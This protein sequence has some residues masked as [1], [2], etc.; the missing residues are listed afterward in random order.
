MLIPALEM[1]N[2]FLEEARYDLLNRRSYLCM[3]NEVVNYFLK[4]LCLHMLL[5]CY[6]FLVKTNIRE[7][8]SLLLT[9]LSI[10][11]CAEE[12]GCLLPRHFNIDLDATPTLLSSSL[13]TSKRKE[14]RNTRFA[15]YYKIW[16]KN[17]TVIRW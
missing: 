9:S 12:I 5:L 14:K 15:S 10:L 7:Y 8:V 4:Q 1:I 17:K 2:P 13:L 16:K 11:I 6:L 3:L